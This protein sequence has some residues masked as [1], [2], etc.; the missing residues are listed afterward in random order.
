[1][2]QEAADEAFSCLRD[3]AIEDTTGGFKF[4]TR[5]LR[6]Y[7]VQKAKDG[8][9]YWMPAFA[10]AAAASLALFA[11]LTLLNQPHEVKPGGMPASEARRMP[12]PTLELSKVP[13]LAQ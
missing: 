5:L 1:M 3:N 12:A 10:G 13:N 8:V 7:R 2:T 11:A 6:R 4:E 9:R